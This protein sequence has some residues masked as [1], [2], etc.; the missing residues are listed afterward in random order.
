MAYSGLGCLGFC[1]NS[2]IWKG[3]TRDWAPVW[4]DICEFE[5]VF[6]WDIEVTYCIFLVTRVIV[7]GNCGLSAASLCVNRRMYLIASVRKVTTSRAEKQRQVA[8][9]LAVGLG[10]P[11]IFLILGKNLVSMLKQL[12]DASNLFQNM[13]MKMC[14]I[15]FLKTLGATT[16]HTKLGLRSSATHFLSLYLT[17]S[18]WY[19]PSWAS[20]PSAE[21]V[22]R[23]RICYLF[24]P[25]WPTVAISVSCSLRRRLRFVRLEF[26]HTLSRR[27]WAKGLHRGPASRT[28]MPMSLSCSST[29]LKSG[30]P[31]RMPLSSNFLGGYGLSLLWVFLPSSAFLKKP[32]SIIAMPWV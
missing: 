8:V 12:R 14:D 32:W 28:F 29:Q 27:T 16:P 4:C 25:A 5:K 3:N 20:V 18:L 2:I 26:S 15:S 17:A 11:I 30:V 21:S 23:V 13:F 6:H 7:I 31:N 22:T 1:I 10:V 19:M 9:D 24:N